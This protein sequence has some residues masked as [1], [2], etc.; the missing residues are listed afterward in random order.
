MKGEID[1]TVV[2]DPYQFGYKSV[3]V[4]AAE[5]RGD[6]SKRVDKPIPYRLV[7]KNGGQPTLDNGV[8]ILN[9]KAEEFRDKLK[10]L[11]E[12]SK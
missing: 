10:Q 11:L 12:E 9:L 3:A 8:E 6:T 1:A 5:I 2:Q 4:L 7:T